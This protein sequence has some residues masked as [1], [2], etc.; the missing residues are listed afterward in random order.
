[1]ND[2]LSVKKILAIYAGV[3]CLAVAMWVGIV[4]VGSLIVEAAFG[5]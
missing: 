3:L 2:E 5:G 1:M 4:Y